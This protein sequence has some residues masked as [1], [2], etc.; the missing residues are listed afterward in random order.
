MPERVNPETGSLKAT[1][2]GIGEVFVGLGAVELI[3]TVGAV[4][5]IVTGK[6]P[7]SALREPPL[8]V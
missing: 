2:N 5:S 4:V 1:V 6:P 8:G 7:D 3:A